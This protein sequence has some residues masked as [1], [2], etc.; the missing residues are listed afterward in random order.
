MPGLDAVCCRSRS[1]MPAE[2]SCS[3]PAVAA[4]AGARHGCVRL[5]CCSAWSRLALTLLLRGLDL[6]RR[7]RCPLPEGDWQGRTLPCTGSCRCSYRR[8]P[9]A[10][11]EYLPADAAAHPLL[12]HTGTAPAQR[13]GLSLAG[14]GAEGD[15]LGGQGAAGA[16]GISLTGLTS[17]GGFVS[18]TVL[19]SVDHLGK[20]SS[21]PCSLVLLLRV[22][23]PQASRMGVRTEE[24]QTV[25]PLMH[26]HHRPHCLPSQRWLGAHLRGA[27]GALSGRPSD[28]SQQAQH[29]IA[30]RLVSG[31]RRL[32]GEQGQPAMPGSVLLRGIVRASYGD[33]APS[34]D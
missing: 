22:R 26:D 1:G 3:A 5:Q 27:A 7:Q 32:P 4:Q 6:A 31:W 23:R 13:R 2:F 25:I 33:C 20:G 11:P 15:G 28:C 34:A 30:T 14:A 18:R 17:R 16:A 19:F 10:V 8:A 9:G 24:P 29:C 12:A 21:F